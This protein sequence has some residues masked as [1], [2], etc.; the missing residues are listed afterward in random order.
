MEI[1]TRSFIVLL[2]NVSTVVY[3]A[4]PYWSLSREASYSLSVAFCAL[5]NRVPP[6]RMLPVLPICSKGEFWQTAVT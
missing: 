3:A 5:A 4:S 2:I 1:L 6:A